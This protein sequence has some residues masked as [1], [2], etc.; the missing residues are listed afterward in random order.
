MLPLLRPIVGVSCRRLPAAGAGLA[1]PRV[2][3]LSNPRFTAAGARRRDPL[4]CRPL[5]STLANSP[6]DFVLQPQLLRG[7]S[8]VGF[9]RI[10]VSEIEV[11]TMLVNLVNLKWMS[12]GTK[13]Q[14]DRTLGESLLLRPLGPD[15]L[16]P[17]YRWA[18]DELLWA[19]HPSSDRYKRPKFEQWFAAGRNRYGVRALRGL[20]LTPW[21]FIFLRT[22]TPGV[23]IAYSECLPTR[24]NPLAERTCFSQ[25]RRRTCL[26]CHAGGGRQAQ[27]RRGRLEPL[28]PAG[29]GEIGGGHR[30]HLAREAALGR[31]E[32]ALNVK[33]IMTRDITLYI[34]LVVLRTKYTGWRLNDFNVY[35]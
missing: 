14:C 34:S 13:R 10:V 16:E 25:V 2:R 23:C 31:W 9:G 3:P 7:E 17:L 27:R 4:R 29:R 20:T 6:G 24:L 32:P 18:S 26:R 21:A 30:L 12:G 19:D 1:R 5:S 15:D 22:S 11:P 35:A 8:L 33:V 28:P